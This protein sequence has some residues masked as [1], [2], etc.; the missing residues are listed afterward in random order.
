VRT[1]IPTIPNMSP[2]TYIQWGIDWV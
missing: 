1:A 2:A